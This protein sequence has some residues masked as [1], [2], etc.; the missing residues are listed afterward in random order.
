MKMVTTIDK[1]QDKE[2]DLKFLQAT[3]GEWQFLKNS[4][5][6][7]DLTADIEDLE[8]IES[9]FFKKDLIKVGKYINGGITYDVTPELLQLV[10]A[11]TMRMIQN[12]REVSMPVETH[13]PEGNPDNNAGF[14][15]RVYIEGDTLFGECE[16]IDDDPD[17]LA[18]RYKV[19]VGIKP[20]QD[21]NGNIYE[22]VVEHV[23]LTATPV[24]IGQDD[25]EPIMFI[26]EEED[27]GGIIPVHPNCSC[28]VIE[29]MWQF[30]ETASGPC[31]DCITLK[32]QWNS[33]QI[34]L[35]ESIMPEKTEVKVDEVEHTHQE[36]HHKVDMVMPLQFMEKVDELVKSSI[37]SPAVRNKI[38]DAVTTMNMS[39]GPL[40]LPDKIIEALK[41]NVVMNLEEAAGPQTTAVL[42][43][44]EETP[45]QIIYDAWA[46]GGECFKN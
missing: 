32:A 42:P 5:Y 2:P 6:S 31:P 13:D 44:S 19:S 33:G 4:E 20:H 24:V 7:P 22:A 29:G 28:R 15:R 3:P 40:S 37:I 41:S 34:S 14:V 35:K 46:S 21:G 26:L 11:E 8:L 16:L 27:A 12:G 9:K 1:K 30:G 25:F 36:T 18:K 10:E 45:E 17:S 39:E 23:A 43:R 38:K